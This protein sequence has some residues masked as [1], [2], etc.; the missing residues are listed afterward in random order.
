MDELGSQLDWQ[1]PV[2]IRENATAEPIPRLKKCNFEF[3]GAQRMRRCQACNA[4]AYNDDFLHSSC[5]GKA[6]HLRQVA[7]ALLVYWV[8]IAAFVV[9][10]MIMVVP[11]FLLHE[12]PPRQSRPH[13]DKVPSIWMFADFILHNF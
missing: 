3:L 1:V 7:G 2:M 8:L 4:P 6:G 12:E 11:L 9:A 10:V 5:G 13:R